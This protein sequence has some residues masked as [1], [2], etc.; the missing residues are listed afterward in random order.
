MLAK[1]LEKALSI[2]SSIDP[3]T[4]RE[5]EFLV[6]YKEYIIAAKKKADNRTLS[7][8][9]GALMGLLRWLSDY[10]YFDQNEALWSSLEDIENYYSKNF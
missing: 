7:P 6:K 2:L 9:N 5:E 1:K 3:M 10:S 8:S 4:T